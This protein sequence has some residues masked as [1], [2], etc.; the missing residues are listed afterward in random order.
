MNPD[1]LECKYAQLV[2]SYINPAHTYIFE[3]LV[4]HFLKRLI[5]IFSY[6][7]F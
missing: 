4:V 1:K 2:R 6:L 7:L 3:F 5:Q